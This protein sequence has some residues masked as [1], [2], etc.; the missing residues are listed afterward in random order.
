MAFFRLGVVVKN[1]HSLTWLQRIL[2]DFASKLGEDTSLAASFRSWKGTVLAT[3]LKTKPQ[4][5]SGDS[6]YVLDI[7]LD[8]RSDDDWLMTR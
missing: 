6:G 7:M 2:D 5:E 8:R 3:Q 4:L 1:T